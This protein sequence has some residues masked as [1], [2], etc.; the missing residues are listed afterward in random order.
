MRE[1]IRDNLIF[2]GQGSKFQPDAQKVALVE[3]YPSQTSDS[4]DT[5]KVTRVVLDLEEAETLHS[6]LG[7][8][9]QEQSGGA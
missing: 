8:W 1:F 7:V 5:G 2:R 3:F 6:F 9:L 4:V